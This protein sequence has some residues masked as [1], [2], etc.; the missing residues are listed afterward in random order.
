[1]PSCRTDWSFCGA[2]SRLQL[3]W[4]SAQIFQAP[5]EPFQFSFEFAELPLQCTALPFEL[6]LVFAQLL[7]LLTPMARELLLEESPM[8]LEP[9]SP[10]L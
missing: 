10:P 2:T 4:G 9:A 7:L 8:L 3:Q 5:A 1:L 6:T